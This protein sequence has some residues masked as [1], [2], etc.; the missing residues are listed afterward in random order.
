[1]G[2]EE[3]AAAAEPTLV[4]RARDP[5]LWDVLKNGRLG[6]PLPT[7][8]ERASDP[9]HLVLG[10]DPDGAGDIDFKLPFVPGGKN[11]MAYLRPD[12]G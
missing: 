9:S 1:M 6:L 3:E 2:A 11:L 12:R 8:V 7:L 5:S 4:E 10:V